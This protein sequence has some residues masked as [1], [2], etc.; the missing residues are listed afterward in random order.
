MGFYWEGYNSSLTIALITFITLSICFVLHL[1]IIGHTSL[2]LCSSGK[3]AVPIRIKTLTMSYLINSFLF[4]LGSYIIR[5]LVHFGNVYLPCWVTDYMFIF[6]LLSRNSL[7]LLFLDRLHCA[8]ENTVFQH[9]KQFLLT[10]AICGLVLFNACGAFFLYRAWYFWPSSAYKKCA[11]HGST[12]YVFA[13]APAILADVIIGCFLIGLFIR[14]SCPISTC[15]L[16]LLSGVFT[17]VNS[18]R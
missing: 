12:D 7:Y 4:V 8:F 17:S 14:S 9:S 10:V 16:C 6:V 3:T 11:D 1:V 15:S 13:I 5:I 18:I 2:Q